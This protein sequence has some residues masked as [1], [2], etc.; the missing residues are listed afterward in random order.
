[1]EGLAELGINKNLI[2][3]KE[4]LSDLLEKEEKYRNEEEDSD[5]GGDDGNSTDRSEEE[6]TASE[7]SQ[8]EDSQ[9]S[10]LDY[11]SKA[12]AENNHSENT[13]LFFQANV[14]NPCQHYEGPNVYDTAVMKCPKCL[15]VDYHK[16]CPLCDDKIPLDGK[17]GEHNLR[18][19]YDFGATIY[20]NEKTSK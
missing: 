20:K 10:H 6:K 12:E 19:C 8:P 16:V 7:S 15:W 4:L 11:H 2:K 18:R 13:C 5:N 3:N 14:L 17:H 1:M 9:N